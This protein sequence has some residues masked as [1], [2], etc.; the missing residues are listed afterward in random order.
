MI[1]E[2]DLRWHQRRICRNQLGTQSF[3]LFSCLLFSHEDVFDDQNFVLY[4]SF[5]NHELNLFVVE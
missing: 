1:Q 5:V 4:F 3:L 2:Q